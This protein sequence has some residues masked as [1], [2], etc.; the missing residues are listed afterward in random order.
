MR[1]ITSRQ[2]VDNT[3]GQNS[4]CGA[5]GCR[6]NGKDEGSEVCDLN[7]SMSVGGKIRVWQRDYRERAE[8]GTSCRI[9]YQ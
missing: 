1:Y 6:G 4:D 7:V 3:R 5:D 8:I 9:I 2:Y